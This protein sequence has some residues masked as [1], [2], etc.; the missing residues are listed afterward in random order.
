M[1]TAK[2]GVRINWTDELMM[3]VGEVYGLELFSAK[4]DGRRAR[5]VGAVQD[6]FKLSEPNANAVVRD[7]RR[8][9]FISPAAPRKDRA[10]HDET[11]VELTK[12]VRDLISEVKKSKCGCS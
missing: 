6:Y 5:P 11:L 10:G 8:R 12:A 3:Q 4:M 9:G 7:G 2:S 1:N